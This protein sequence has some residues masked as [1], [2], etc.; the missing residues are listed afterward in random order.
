MNKKIWTIILSI[1]VIFSFT[2]AAYG[3]E[4]NTTSEELVLLAINAQ[5]PA[6]DAYENL[7]KCFIKMGN[8]IVYPDEYGGCYI[9]DN[10]LNICLTDI[11]ETN[12]EKYRGYCATEDVVNFVTVNYSLNYLNTI[13]DS[14]SIEAV[15]NVVSIGVCQSNNSVDI[16]VNSTDFNKTEREIESVTNNISL[17]S[18]S[19]EL[20]I[21][22]YYSEKAEPASELIG[23]QQMSANSSISLGVCGTYSGN[24]AILTCG[25]TLYVGDNV[26][27]NGTKVGEVVVRRFS[28]GSNYDYGIVK[29]TNTST[30][31]RTNKVKNDANNTTITSTASSSPAEGTLVCKYGFKNGFGVGKVTNSSISVNYGEEVIRKLV[32]VSTT[33]GNTVASGD[34]GGP[35]Y[36]GH[37]YHGGVSGASGN[38]WYFSPVHGASSFTVK[39][40]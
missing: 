33:T 4:L 7:L 26:Y 2:T 11:S 18:D 5:Q 32:Q 1:V 9:S 38:T 36:R 21:N 40:S 30:F 31:T 16:G 29:I 12:K 17:F 13:A 25:H 27:I 23:G 15:E 35:V 34:S 6:I 10:C 8:E 39:T 20:P 19:N 14:I 22:I 24:P 28:D 37:T 3:N